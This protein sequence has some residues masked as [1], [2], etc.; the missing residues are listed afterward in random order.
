MAKNIRSA[1]DVE[2]EISRLMESSLVKMAMAYKNAELKRRQL[3]EELQELETLGIELADAGVTIEM[4]E[5][6]TGELI[7]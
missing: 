3:M 6:I 4:V 5:G 1:A 7:L 2:R